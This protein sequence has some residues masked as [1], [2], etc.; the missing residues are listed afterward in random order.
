M[1]P[2]N[3]PFCIFVFFVL[4]RYLRNVPKHGVPAVGVS[5]N[6]A[7]GLLPSRDFTDL[8]SYL[9]VA[10][11]VMGLSVF[12]SEEGV[13]LSSIIAHNASA[14][15]QLYLF[16]HRNKK[17]TLEIRSFAFFVGGLVYLPVR[18]WPSLLSY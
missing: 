13:P 3:F 14:L 18:P 10:L 6:Y 4:F 2:F 5:H 15:Q 7:A 9:L 1:L 16:I 17:T 11:P 8:T 12:V